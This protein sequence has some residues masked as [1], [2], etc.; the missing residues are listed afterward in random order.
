[1]AGGFWKYCGSREARS[2][3]WSGSGEAWNKGHVQIIGAALGA[4]SFYLLGL[5]MPQWILSDPF[6]SFLATTIFGAI[7]GVVIVFTCRIILWC[8][9]VRKHGSLKN[10]FGARTVPIIF[11]AVGAVGALVFAVG[12]V[13]FAVDTALAARQRIVL[14]SEVEAKVAAIDSMYH[15]MARSGSELYSSTTDVVFPW[16]A[17]YNA[18]ETMLTP[19]QIIN[20]IKNSVKKINV[21]C[22]MEAAMYND[23]DQ[24]M[25]YP[26]DDYLKNVTPD[27]PKQDIRTGARILLDKI[28]EIDTN[29]NKE[30]V[31]MLVQQAAGG[32]EK[33]I[34]DFRKWYND[35]DAA[36]RKERASRLLK[37]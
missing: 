36:L 30:Y 10:L 21:L 14:K 6:L 9:V 34:A 1:M 18:R 15:A 29:P 19:E 13:W 7:T 28:D 5:T 16:Q 26:Y 24:A 2:Y 8:A 17:A 12:A 27:R 35:V 4:V 31:K 37:L 25:V 32:F 11:M 22:S 23:I 33:S 3:A 20:D